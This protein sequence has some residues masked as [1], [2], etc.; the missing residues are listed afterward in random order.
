MDKDDNNDDDLQ[1]ELLL[2]CVGMG[3]PG[4]FGVPYPGKLGVPKPGRLG[5]CNPG[6]LIGLVSSNGSRG[7]TWK[8]FVKY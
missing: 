3:N 7:S 4:R 2:P 1:L 6:W 5:F 8:R